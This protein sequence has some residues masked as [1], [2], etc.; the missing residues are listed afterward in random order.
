MGNSEK[1]NSSMVYWSNPAGNSASALL[2]AARTSARVAALS[3]P[4]SNSSTTL[5]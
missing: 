4:N 2:M 5:A 3:Q 1:L